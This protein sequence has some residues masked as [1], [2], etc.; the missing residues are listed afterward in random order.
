MGL[1]ARSDTNGERAYGCQTAEF[2]SLNSDANCVF[3]IR[4][5]LSSRNVAM[6]TQKTTLFTLMIALPIVFTSFL[7]QPMALAQTGIAA[8]TASAQDVAAQIGVSKAKTA[9]SVSVTGKFTYGVSQSGNAAPSSYTLGQYAY[10][11]GKNNLGFLAHNYLAGSSF[12]ML[13]AGDEVL[14]TF[15]DGSTQTYTVYNVTRDKATDPNNFSKPFVDARGKTVSARQVFNQ[16]YKSNQVTFQTCL[17]GG[18]SLTWGVLI[19][20]ARPKK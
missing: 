12:Y 6:T 14:V 8:D 9:V 3:V 11:A 20:Q 10:A 19:V 17:S 7:N 15:S 13:S 18:G 1:R 2:Y 5:S 4:H 16:A